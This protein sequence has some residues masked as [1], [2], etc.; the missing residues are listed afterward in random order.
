MQPEKLERRV[1]R[2]EERQAEITHQRERFNKRQRNRRLLNILIL[3]VVLVA[4]GYAVYVS[5]RPQDSGQY[6]GFARCLTGE[7]VVMYGTEW[8][9]HC[10]D[11]KRLFGESFRYVAFVNC[12]LDAAACA[13]V[14]VTQFPTWVYPDRSRTTGLLPLAVLADR[15]GCKVQ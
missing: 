7:G 12:D 15:T 1:K 2:K 6:D 3:C 11:Q 8:C 13:A 14:N 10:Q 9:P 4:A 5:F